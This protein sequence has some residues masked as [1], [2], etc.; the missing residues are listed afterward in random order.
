[1][2]LACIYQTGKLTKHTDLRFS[3]KHLN[4]DLLARKLCLRFVKKNH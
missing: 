2:Y 1:M 3:A 4:M